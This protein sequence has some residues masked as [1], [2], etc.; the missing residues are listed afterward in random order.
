MLV[1]LDE[2]PDGRPHFSK[3]DGSVLEYTCN[4]ILIDATVRLSIS[5]TSWTASHKSRLQLP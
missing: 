1:F 5:A 2:T 4:A 3:L